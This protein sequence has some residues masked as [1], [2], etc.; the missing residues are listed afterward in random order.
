MGAGQSQPAALGAAPGA[1]A[2]TVPGRV[3]VEKPPVNATAVLVGNNNKKKKANA[4]A[5]AAAPAAPQ[6]TV[7]VNVQGGGRRRKSR[8][9]RKA[10]KSRKNR[11][12]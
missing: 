10:R 2:P 11:R 8:K 9:S 5:A 4:A 6:G 1:A 3:N 12:S 7:A